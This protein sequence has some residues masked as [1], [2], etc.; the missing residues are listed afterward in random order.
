M[1]IQCI[2][3]SRWPRAYH[4]LCRRA[5]EQKKILVLPM[6]SKAASSS[7]TNLFKNNKPILSGV[8]HSSSDFS[9]N[10][11]ILNISTEMKKVLD[12]VDVINLKTLYTLPNRH[13]Q[14]LLLFITVKVKMSIIQ[15]TFNDLYNEIRNHGKSAITNPNYESP[16]LA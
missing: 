6:T 3:K 10:K 1:K 16:I 14:R 13:M 4:I 15:K 5:N 7:I 11:T 2:K 9:K 8:D 12:Q